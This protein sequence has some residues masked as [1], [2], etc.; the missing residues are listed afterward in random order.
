[1]QFNDPVNKGGRPLK[2]KTVEE[3]EQRIEQ[4]FASLYDYARDM[5]GNRLKDKE[6]VKPADGSDDNNPYAGW[7][8]KKVKVAT[9]TGLAVYLDTSRDVLIDYERGKYDEVDEDGNKIELSDIEQLFN[10]QVNTFSNTISRAKAMILEDTE[11]QLYKSGASTG[12]I[13]SLRVNYK[14]QDKTVTEFSNPDGSLNPFG[15]LT[16]EELRKIAEG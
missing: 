5:W 12:A 8:M 16:V 15:K 4:Y 9:I 11:Q 3:L 1:M 2:F 14:W 7:V 6:Y 13:F 10:E